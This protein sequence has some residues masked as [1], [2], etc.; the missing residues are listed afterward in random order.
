MN[1]RTILDQ[2]RNEWVKLTHPTSNSRFSRDTTILIAVFVVLAGLTGSIFPVEIFRVVVASA[3]ILDDVQGFPV[4][5]DTLQPTATPTQSSLSSPII[6]DLPSEVEIEGISGHRQSLPLSCEARSAVDWA[7][8]FG[9]DIDEIQFFDGLPTHDNPELGFVGDVNGS[10]GQIPPKPYGVHAKPVAQRLREFG[11]NAKAVRGMTWEE[12]QSE[13]A[14]NQPVILWV[15]GHVARGTPV[16]YSASDG[17]I[18]TV[19]KFEHTVLAIGYTE[20]KIT[21]LDG[22]KVYSRHKGEFLKSWGVLEN[23]AVIWID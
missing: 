15:V 22:A 11:L 10:W 1:T 16:P 18:T 17:E 2:I 5:Q 20:N 7:A 21:V 14:D 6:G 8:F 4:D 12:L 13:L 23:Q 3:A 19:A 9:R